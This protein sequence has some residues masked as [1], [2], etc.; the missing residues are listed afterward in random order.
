MTRTHRPLMPRGFV[1]FGDDFAYV[2]L[3][4]IVALQGIPAPHW[5]PSFSSQ[6]R[7]GWF[8]HTHPTPKQ[9]GQFLSMQKVIYRR[10]VCFGRAFLCPELP[11][12]PALPANRTL[13]PCPL[14]YRLAPKVYRRGGQYLF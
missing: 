9:T 1:L 8:S 6:V 3:V 10:S 7:S 4:A 2:G 12:I 5:Q 13:G 14:A 11:A